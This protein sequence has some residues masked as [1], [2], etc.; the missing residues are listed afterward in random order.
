MIG[1]KDI[2]CLIG[3][4]GAGKTTP[5]SVISCLHYPHKGKIEFFGKDITRFRPKEIVKEG[6]I[7]IPEGRELFN[8]LTVIEN[9]EMG[10]YVRFRNKAKDKIKVDIERIVNMF[11]IFKARAGQLAG[12]LSGGEQQCWLSNVGL[13]GS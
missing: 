1:V 11:P 5:L 10:V 6:I 8:A 9:L 13:W 7:R 3:A 12:T 4:N 2:V